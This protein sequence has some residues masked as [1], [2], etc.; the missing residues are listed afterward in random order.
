MKLVLI[1]AVESTKVAFDALVN[2]QLAPT[3]VVTLPPSKAARHSDFV[4]LTEPATKIGAKVIYTNNINDEETIHSLEK[5]QPDLCLVLGW[6]QICREPFRSISRFGNI[7]FHPSPLP[8]LRG[9][10]VIPWTIIL[11]MKQTAS[12]LFLLEEGADTGDIVAQK[13]FD[14]SDAETARSLYDKHTKALVNMIPDA[15]RNTLSGSAK[16]QVQDHSEAS[17]CAKRTPDDG[18]INW[19]DSAVKIERFIRAVGAPYPG[20]FSATPENGRIWIDAAV[21]PANPVNYIG[22]PG[23]IQARTENSFTVMCGDYNCIEVTAWRTETKV[24]LRQH[25]LLGR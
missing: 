1:G 14:V 15:V 17:Y 5:I 8:K 20:A 6:S 4:D 13:F 18:H 23:Q 21:L 11:N 3:H 22:M 19:A 16:H 2:A 12:T 10:A 24:P 25:A 9:R 7:G